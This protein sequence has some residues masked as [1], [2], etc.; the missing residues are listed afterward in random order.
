ML[1]QSWFKAI[2]WCGEQVF[3]QWV[4]SMKHGGRTGSRSQKL[5]LLSV[6]RSLSLSLRCRLTCYERSRR[7]H[8]QT[9]RLSK[10]LKAEASFSPTS[11]RCW[12]CQ[13][14]TTNREAQI[15]PI[16][17]D[18]Y[19]VTT[20]VWLWHTHSTVADCSPV[21][22]WRQWKTQISLLAGGFCS[23]LLGNYVMWSL[24]L[25]HATHGLTW[26]GENR[27]HQSGST[28]LVSIN[29]PVLVHRR[30]VDPI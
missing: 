21:P 29:W 11:A 26:A 19:C 30:V 2:S 7:L 28:H 3:V 12:K 15:Q 18:S 8:G 13:K 27:P 22:H 24:S 6:S 10:S 14:G 5:K 20:K 25:Y 4:W 16:S 1:K 9:R 23:L 17:H